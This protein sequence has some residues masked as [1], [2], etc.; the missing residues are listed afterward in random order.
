MFLSP[1]GAVWVAAPQVCF[2][3]TSFQSNCFSNLD[4]QLPSLC[5]QTGLTQWCPK[6]LPKMNIWNQLLAASPA[7][8]NNDQALPWRDHRGFCRGR[9]A[10]RTTN[11]TELVLVAH[12]RIHMSAAPRLLLSWLHVIP[13]AITSIVQC[14]ETTH[15]QLIGLFSLCFY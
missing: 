13:Y 7:D 6:L 1:Q 12:T 2:T 11:N 10:W 3:L 15:A 14:I 4:F 8:C 9:R 5:L